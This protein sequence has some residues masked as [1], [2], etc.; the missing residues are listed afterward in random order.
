MRDKDF[1]TSMFLNKVSERIDKSLMLYRDGYVL[2]N[3]D[4]P[5]QLY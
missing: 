1:W 3:I 5:I 4:Q 2:Y